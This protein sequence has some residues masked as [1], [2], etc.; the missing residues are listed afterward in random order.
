MRGSIV[1]WVWNCPGHSG[2]MLS[3]VAVLAPG[4][5]NT[6]DTRAE[7]EAWFPLYRPSP[8]APLFSMADGQSYRRSTNCN[9]TRTKAPTCGGGPRLEKLQVPGGRGALRIPART[10]HPCYFV[11]CFSFPGRVEYSLSGRASRRG[12]CWG[13]HRSAI[14]GGGIHCDPLEWVF[15]ICYLLL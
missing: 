3:A 6:T 5:T 14:V 12:R 9:F 10:F 8:T 1:R 7:A 13:N 11:R 2:T 4:A 15:A